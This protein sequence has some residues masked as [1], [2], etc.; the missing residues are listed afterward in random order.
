MNCEPGVRM[1]E[2]QNSRWWILA[3]MGAILGVIL[4]DETVVGVALPTIQKDI[5]LTANGAHWVVNVYLLTLAA[6]A[7]A[8]GRLGDIIGVRVLVVAGLVIF[9]VSSTIC[10]FAQDGATL[11]AA[12]MAQG[13]GAAV[14][15]PLSLVLVTMSFEEGERGKALGIYGAIGTS[16]LALG[17][18]VGGFLTEYLSWRWIFWINPPIVLVVAAIVWTHWRDQPHP[19]EGGFDWAGLVLMVGGLTLTVF[20]IMEGPERGWGDALTLGTLGLGLVMLLALVFWELRARPPLIAVGLFANPTFAAANMIVLLAQ[21]A[22]ISIFVFGAMYFQSK[23]GLSP[24]MAGVAL[25]PAVVPSIFMASVAGKASDEHGARSP[26]LVGVLGTL[27]SLGLT[28]IGMAIGV[29]LLVY[30]GF[31]AFGAA[32]SFLFV[33]PQRAVMGAVPMGMQ[34]QAG[35]LV[36]SSQLLG[37]TIGMAISAT[38]FAMTGSFPAVF[39]ATALAAILVLVYSYA[40]L[41]MPEPEPAPR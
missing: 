40:V 7:A 4:L 5:G 22:K 25:L 30:L 36:L 21:Y 1:D 27:V 19:P 35:G 26:S 12:R 15:F 23:A 14:I 32:V 34:G 37:G 28:A 6:L 41:D 29:N 2:S 8:S 20:G 16:L 13:V 17:P 39:L 24:L 33:P 9:G 10:G 18:L 31:F 3:A 38:I 11:I